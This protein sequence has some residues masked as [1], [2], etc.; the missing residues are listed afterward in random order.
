MATVPTVDLNCAHGDYPLRGLEF[1]TMRAQNLLKAT[2]AALSLSLGLLSGIAP[3][4]A[5]TLEKVPAPW[6]DIYRAA[7]TS[8]ASNSTPHVGSIPQIPQ[9]KH[10][11][12]LSNFKVT[13]VNVPIAEQTAV[14]A[15]IDTWSDNW[16][17]SV[18]VNVV[19]NFIPAGTSGILASASPVS[20]FHNF[21]GI[22]DSTLWYSSAMANALAGKDLDPAN[23]EISININS[24]MAN[25]FY[26]ATDGN[27]PSNLYDLESII[28]HE[29]AHGLGFLSNNSFDSFSQYGSI[30]Q[31]TPFDTY[32]QTPDG[33][34][35]VDLASPSISLG[36]A[37]QNTLIWSG[38]NAIAANNGIK[39]ALYTPSRYEP[40]SSVSHLDETTFQGSGADALMTPAWP[41]GSVFHSPSPIVLAMLADMRQKPPA[42]IPVRI[43]NAPR[44]VFAIVGNRSALVSFD[45]PDNARTS[46][47]ASYAITVNETG[48]V[49]QTTT[50]PVTI[51]GLVNGSHY[52]FSVTASN[53]LGV[54]PAQTSN[55]IFPQSPWKSSVLDPTS[56]AKYLAIT[57]FQGSP[58]VVYTDSKSGD[59]KL[60]MW[61]GKSWVKSTVDG[62][63]TIGGRTTDN[64]AGYVSLCT[65]A[66]GK[67]QRLD[68]VYADLS[69]KQ[70]RYAGYNGKS[71]KFTVV[72]C[73]GANVIK[74]NDVN[75]ARTASDV[76]GASACVDTADGLQ[77]FY[78]DQSEGI[79]LAAVQLGSAIGKWEYQV[80]DGDATVK[81]RTTG[82][83]GFHLKALNIGR[84]I[85]L[86][87]DSILQVN[88]QKQALQ[89]EV[90]LATRTSAYAEDWKYSVLD[91]YGGE[92]AVAGYD[93]ALD[94]VGRDVSGVWMAASG[95]A[96][97]NPNQLRLMDITNNG[98]VISAS[99]DIYGTPSAPLN[100]DGS[101]TL[102]NCQNR[103]CAINNSAQTV[104]LVTTSS[105]ENSLG[106]FWITI[107]RVRYA[108]VGVGGKLQLFKAV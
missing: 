68:I 15:A 56:D 65:T 5:L 62:N 39:P 9:G 34:R 96:I 86:L 51:T 33:G 24:T 103:L 90:R 31:P 88:Q 64:I 69:N 59:L 6:V 20:F 16:S 81:G 22:P 84:S 38:K 105:M 82:D 10:V 47:V 75:R 80:V 12:A 2:L 85:Y 40:G 21:K 66:A 101:H 18:P 4:H 32:A 95:I 55:A 70:L 30:D 46:Q 1:F 49:V 98:P 57:T 26:L 29:I 52:S 27:C 53:Q 108:L 14:Q 93:V 71:W 11:N 92:V 63:S 104:S 91:S 25:A 60:A 48:R 45:P 43:P 79:I 44:N 37:L 42:G 13:Y 17:S 107:N 97:P 87:Y 74:F 3:S 50:S 77:I 28:L 83:V 36:L 41:G 35:L 19:A 61:N 76:S 67:N 58:T 23:P 102:F 94:N 78:R 106:A 99:T 54:S 73:N 8:G 7:A 72:D 100:T 89:G